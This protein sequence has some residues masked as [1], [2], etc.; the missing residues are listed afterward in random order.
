MEHTRFFE[1]THPLTILTLIKKA[2]LL[3]T[4]PIIR[5]ALSLRPESAISTVFVWDTVLI[6]LI[7]FYGALRWRRF[8]V[9]VSGK[10]L[11]VESG[12]IIKRRTAV[13]AEKIACIYV[14][15]SPFSAIFKAV[16][17]S[18]EADNRQFKKPVFSFYLS[19]ANAE[20]LCRLLK[21]EALTHQTLSC[22]VRKILLLSLSNA[23]A[24]SGLLVAATL[25]TNIGKA[26]GNEFE[27][28][29]VETLSSV[30]LLASQIIPP[31]AFVIATVLAA[32][33]IIS[34]L[35]ALFKHA[36]FTLS[37]DKDK[38]VI[39][40]GLISR[41]TSIIDRLYISAVSI[42]ASPIMKLLG[43]CSV[44]LYA[45]G[46][47]TAKSESYAVI[48]VEK[49]TAV[50]SAL[51]NAD[52]GFCKSQPLTLKVPK[53]AMSR[54]LFLPCVYIVIIIALTVIGLI[55]IEKLTQFI[56]LLTAFLLV[57][58]AYWLFIRVNHIKNGGAAVNDNIRL[59]SFRL[60]TVTDIRFEKT[61]IDCVIITQGPFDR[62]KKL[63]TLK[64]MLKGKS[65]YTARVI[66]LDNAE[67]ERLIT[68]TF[69]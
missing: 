5:E 36:G 16:K 25:I 2:L 10:T 53:R 57:T 13:S 66:N 68:Q 7:I 17:I 21:P 61:K 4:L 42:E 58:N 40:K 43:R 39:R 27:N 8:R 32:G 55:F 29:L 50:E 34:F 38:L 26:V 47:G 49:A 45:C 18:I 24:F 11:T 30:A 33:F 64:V 6:A 56:L 35:I 62:R 44:M 23:S 22:S 54:A 37:T 14:T 65:A 1:R 59:Y 46:H 3:L 28:R 63:C 19:K 15:K 48:P 52:F 31:T 69:L 60:F 51:K 20:R 12:L 9:S 41:K 67:T